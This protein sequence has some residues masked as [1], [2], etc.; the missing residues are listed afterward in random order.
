MEFKETLE[1]IQQQ[2]ASVRKLFESEGGQSIRGAKN[3]EYMTRLAEAAKFL[4][5]PQQGLVVM[6]GPAQARTLAAAGYTREECIQWISDHCVDTYAK[7]K[8]MGL[9]KGVVGTVFRRQGVPINPTGQWPAEWKDPNFDP[10]TI[11]K[12]YPNTLGITMIVSIGSYDGLIM[13]GTPRW[14]VA[15]DKWR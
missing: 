1:S 4:S 2:E 6:I 3:A 15:I 11:V 9:G 10:N 5:R 12:Y 13:N 8:Q 14:T 7:A